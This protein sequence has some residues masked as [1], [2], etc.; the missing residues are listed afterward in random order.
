MFT[1]QDARREKQAQDDRL[2]A[3]ADDRAAAQREIDAVLKANPQI[4]VLM[5]MGK[6]VYY[7]GTREA[8]HPSELI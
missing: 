7:A 3:K 6:P 8:S 1:F 4:G 2:M 5:R